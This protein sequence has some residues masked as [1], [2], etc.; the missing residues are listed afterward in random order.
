[1]AHDNGHSHG[2]GHA[3]GSGVTDARALKTALT[4]ILAFM[5]VEVTVGVIASSLALL[6][7]AAH[8]LTDAAALAL[9]LLALRIA[10]RPARGSMTYGFGRVE[11]LSAQANGVTLLLLGSWITFEAIRRLVDP[12]EVEGGLVL[13]VAVLG[14][15]VN[16]AATWVL[17]RANRESLNVEGS[18][19]HILTDL[20]AF[21]ATAIAGAVILLTGFERADPIASLLVAGSMFIAGYGLVKA[22][23]R[24]FLEAAPE[25]FDPEQI[26]MTLARH[27]GV[28]EVHDLH[29]WEVTSGFP[30]LSAHVVAKKGLDLH[31]LRLALAAELDEQFGL[32]HTT[33]QLDHEQGPLQIAPLGAGQPAEG[34]S[35][36]AP[37]S[38]SDSRAPEK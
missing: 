21:I 33:L 24:V 7:D 22:S 36:T 2:H 30:A 17:A 23:A 25:G 12:P 32:H 26:G 11:I 20:Y 38:P 34:V 3:H 18:F 28:V 1:M 8:M 37:D 15:F 16:L 5:C 13:A 6:S 27:E 14:I 31:E 19:Q 10:R 29:V 9:S 35:A 4:L